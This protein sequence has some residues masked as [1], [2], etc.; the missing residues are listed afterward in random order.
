MQVVIYALAVGDLIRK[1]HNPRAFKT[2]VSPHELLQAVTQASKKQF[3]LT[4]QV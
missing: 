3:R 1:I 4:A 2:H